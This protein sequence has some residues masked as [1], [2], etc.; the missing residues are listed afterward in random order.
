M[1]RTIRKERIWPGLKRRILPMT[2]ALWLLCMTLL[3]CCVAADMVQQLQGELRLYVDHHGTRSQHD[4]TELPGTAE[5]NMI[6]ALGY[7]IYSMD[8]DPLLPFV[9]QQLLRNGVSSKEWLWGKWELYYG[10]ESAVA[11][12]DENG[13]E[14]ISTGDY[15]GFDY[16]SS[17][18][19]K[20]QDLTVLGKSYVALDKIPGACEAFEH[21]I[22]D[23]PGGDFGLFML[24]PLFRL[25]GW[26]EGNEFHATLIEAGDYLDY[27]GRVMDTKRLAEVDSRGKVEWNTIVTAEAPVGQEL[28]TIYGW[29]TFGHN[30]TPKPVTVRGH[31]F[32][33]LTELLR[34]A[35][36]QDS[37]YTLVKQN[38]SETVL[39]EFARHSDTFGAYRMAAAV[40]C[41]P[42]MY[43]M[44]RLVWVYVISFGVVAFILFRSLRTIRRELTEPMEFLAGAIKVGHNIT[45]RSDWLEPEAIEEDFIRTRQTLAENKTELQQLRTALDYAHDA[46]EKR[47]A[48]ISNI[49]HELKTPLAIIHSYTE[50]LQEDVAPEKREQYLATILEE[51]ERM[52][53]LVLQMLELSR[54]EAGKVRLASDSFSLL[55]LTKAIG[56]KM[57]PMLKE[58]EL[59]LH[60]DLA[61]PFFITADEGRIAQ[62]IT[63]LLSNAQKYTTPGGDIRIRIYLTGGKA[64]FQI[65][66]SAP[67]LSDEA[68]E[69]VFDSFYRGDVS[70]N[71]P[72]VGL[73]LPLVKSIIAL[74]GGTVSV[75]NTMMSGTETGVQFGFVLPLT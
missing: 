56:V 22:S 35:H 61:E 38:L 4:D 44:V 63:N 3:T 40:R 2:L 36:E 32:D 73:G 48:L 42:L 16:T 43:A 66:N 27:Q 28:V 39:I 31:H 54:L 10:F 23:Y 9:G 68:L 11:Y 70:R 7:P 6:Q 33:S 8:I 51:T 60:Y 21:R 20:A 5:H 58:R 45:P 69:K 34:S 30:V 19:W 15:L 71:T 49:T 67:H 1:R 26:F 57:E 59:T 75:C 37:P 65:E 74:H 14:M 52:D 72:G 41:R 12:F 47:K 50:C 18:N 13:N 64:Y 46:E 17:E 62:V 25:T 29:E 24:H 53:G 55:E